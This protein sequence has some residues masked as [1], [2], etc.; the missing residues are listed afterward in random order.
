MSAR[1]PSPAW[2][3]PSVGRSGAR[4]ATCA[5]GCRARARG[6]DSA[7]TTDLTD[8]SDTLRDTEETDM[9]MIPAALIE[10]LPKGISIDDCTITTCG[11]LRVEFDVDTCDDDDAP[12]IVLPGWYANDGY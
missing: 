12:A 1:G 6:A 10:A 11:A 8:A 7:S 3:A 2:S 4:A 9:T 5:G